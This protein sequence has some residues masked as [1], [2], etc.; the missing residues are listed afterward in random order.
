MFNHPASHH[1]AKGS[2]EDDDDA[3]IKGGI[4]GSKL[5]LGFEK[6][7]HKSRENGKDQAFGS[8]IETDAHVSAVTEESSHVIVDGFEHALGE[9]DS[10]VV[11]FFCQLS[12]FLLVEKGRLFNLT[13]LFLLLLLNLFP[14]R[15][16]CGKR[17]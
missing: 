6:F 1:H 15:K 9:R 13:R 12:L 5:E 8:L 14:A 4:R 10:V 16:F 3:H 2:E 7:G 17:K 11:F